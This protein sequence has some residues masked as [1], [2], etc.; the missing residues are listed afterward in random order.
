MRSRSKCLEAI[1]NGGEAKGKRRFQ[2]VEL[3]LDFGTKGVEV[4]LGGD[5][6][7]WLGV[8]TLHQRR[9]IFVGRA[10]WTALR[11]PDRPEAVQAPGAAVQPTR[12]LSG[13]CRGLRACPVGVSEMGLQRIQHSIS[14]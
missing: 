13:A 12:S 10:G 7:P 2:L 9:R 14:G 4:A 6:R 5:L 8:Q 11:A 3:C 1:T